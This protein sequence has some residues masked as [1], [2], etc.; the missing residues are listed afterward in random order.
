MKFQRTAQV[1][2]AFQMTREARMDNSDWPAW[3]GEAWQKPH[4][5]IGALWPRDWPDSDGTDELLLRENDTWLTVVAFGNWIVNEDGKLTTLSH[6][7]FANLYEAVMPADEEDILDQETLAEMRGYLG[8][9]QVLG[10]VEGRVAEW[11]N[12]LTHHSDIGPDYDMDAHAV[13]LAIFNGLSPISEILMGV[14]FQ[15]FGDSWTA[16]IEELNEPFM[17]QASLEDIA[18]MK[19]RGELKP[20]QTETG[21]DMPEGFWDDAI[22]G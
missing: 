19:S 18:V 2:E 4:G 15:R 13:E 16:Y 1:V 6:S 17:L 14:G 9:I 12:F 11:A 5:E 8:A 21:S 7:V 22:K 10:D 3:L 20:T